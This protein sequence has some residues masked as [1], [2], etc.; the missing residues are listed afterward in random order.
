M[1]MV[2]PGMPYLDM[3]REVKNKVSAALHSHRKPPLLFTQIQVSV[4]QE[5]ILFMNA[6]QFSF[7]CV[8]PVQHPN[9]PLAVYNVSGEFAMLWH[10]AQAGAFDLKAAV[11]E[12]M[13]AFRRAGET[14]L[15]LVSVVYTYI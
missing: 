14:G 12:A 11:M 13:T 2:K 1:L 5:A 10:G 9:H 6:T 3:V 7:L 8:S 15:P 4:L